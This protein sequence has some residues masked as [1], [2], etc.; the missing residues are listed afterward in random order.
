M[1]LRNLSVT[2][3]MTCRHLPCSGLQ[4]KVRFTAGKARVDSID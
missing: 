2:K 4:N 3:L 1:G